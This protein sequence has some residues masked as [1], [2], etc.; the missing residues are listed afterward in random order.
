MD[1]L[2]CTGLFELREGLLVLEDGSV[3]IGY[4]VHSFEDEVLGGEGYTHWIQ[5]LLRVVAKW[6]VG[7]LLQ[8]LDVYY[9]QAGHLRHR[10]YLY[11]LVPGQAVARAPHTTFLATGRRGLQGALDKLGATITATQKLARTL[12]STFQPR[13]GEWSLSR[14]TDEEN[15]HLLYAYFNLDFVTPTQGFENT[16]VNTPQGLQLG[17]Q[18]VRVVS[19]QSQAEKVHYFGHNPW[20]VTAPFA[21]PLTHYLP[22]AHITVQ[23]IRLVDTEKLLG[24]RSEALDWSAGAKTKERSLRNALTAREDLAAFETDLKKRGG[25]LSTL[26]LLVIV[27]ATR[28]DVV[29]ERV[30]AVQKALRKLQLQPLVETYDT[31]NLFFAAMPAGG[32][33]LYRGLPMPLETALAYMNPITPRKGNAEGV[34]LADRHGTPIRY[35]PFNTTLDNQN[36]FVFGP[37]GSGKSFFNGKLI[38]ERYE[39]GHVVLVIDSGGTYR[40]LFEVLGGKYIEYSAEKPLGLNP[41]LLKKQQGKYAPSLA[42]VNFL[43]QLL[44]KMWKGDLNKNPLKEA[45]KALLARWIPAYYQQEAGV[46]T[47]TRFYDWLQ[48]WVQGAPE[49]VTELEGLFAFQ[50]FLVVLEPFAHGVYAAHFNAG[51]VDHLTNHRLLCFELEA[52]K[53]HPKLYPLVVQ[54]LFDL[55]FALVEAYPTEQKFI[56]VEEGWAMLD[57][58]AAEN[59]EAFFR[60]GRKTKTSIRLITQDIEEIKHSRIAGAM[61]NNAST[62][63]LLYNEKASSRAEMG[64]FLGL[65]GLEMDKYASLQRTH[66]YREVLIKEMDKAHVWRVEVSPYEHAMLTS[67]PEERDR[68]TQLI[69][70]KGEVQRGIKAWVRE[71]Y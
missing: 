44:G 41:F 11:L 42:K 68:I 51:E 18:H 71:L 23:A 43:T 4:K 65:S 24:R 70:E 46:P 17:T 69:A 32:L 26:D 47:L 50:D 52:V 53:G 15:L 35:D 40:R 12:E 63:I 31:T 6:P 54:V 45:E 30:E 7:T 13:P 37:S 39:A 33:Q 67:K 2:A 5:T 38:K 48:A 10:A 62:C 14:L 61:V 1:L 19:M 16:L 25:T 20:G 66:M 58:Y 9:P 49:E 55:A 3:G 36:A 59:I 27:Y 21:W 57:D 8:K 64:A 60:K 28:E 22:F 56:D 29:S 34:L